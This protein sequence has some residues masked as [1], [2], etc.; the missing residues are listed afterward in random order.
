[1]GDRGTSKDHHKDGKGA[2]EEVRYRGVRRRAGGKYASEIRD[3]KNNGAR[4]WLGTF[5]TAEEAARAHDKAAFDMRGYMAVLNF[6]DEYPPTFSAATYN[7]NVNMTATSSMGESSS[8]GVQ[9]GEVF[10]LEYLDGKL[11]DDLLNYYND[12]RT[13]T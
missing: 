5:A 7:N 4:V 2:T 8:S 13:K 11:L 3:T 12:N 1:M 6:P 9:G 10:E